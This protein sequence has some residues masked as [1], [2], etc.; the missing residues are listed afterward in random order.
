M[1]L[2]QLARAGVLVLV[3]PAADLAAAHRAADAVDA[4]VQVHRT[5][6]LD[7]DG[8]LVAA[9]AARPGE[10]WV[11]RPDAHV[12]AVLTG[13]DAETLATALRRALGDGRALGDVGGRE[14]VPDDAVPGE[15]R[16]TP[17]DSAPAGA[18]PHHPQRSPSVTADRGGA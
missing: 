6:E 15:D 17:H 9:L 10:V 2:R 8:G 7:P 13:P 14:G 18:V 16:R 11:V 4:P 1:R 5:A 3:L 12:A